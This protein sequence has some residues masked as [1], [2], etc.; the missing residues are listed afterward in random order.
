M[1]SLLKIVTWNA[2]GLLQ[3]SNELEIFLMRENIDICL[4]SETHLTRESQIK[5]RG[6]AGYHAYH[7]SDRARGGSSLFIKTNIEHSVDINIE[8]E[9]LQLCAVRV[10]NKHL[11]Y[12][13]ASIYCPPRCSLEKDD[14]FRVFN[15]LGSN[16]LIGGDLNAKHTF[17]GS[18]CTSSKGK[19]LYEVANEFGCCFH[20]TG[21]PTYWPTD[22]GKIP[23]LVDFFVTKGIY[24]KFIAVEESFDLS[25]DHSP[26]ILL[27]GEALI[28]KEGPPRLTSNRTNWE[29]FRNDC[30]TNIALNVSLKTPFELEDEVDRFVEAIQRAAWR[31]TPSRSY[32]I[33]RNEK[34]PREI[35]ELVREKRK[36]RKKWQNTRA[37]QHKTVL[38]RL[39]N[40]LRDSIREFKSNKIATYLENLS[41]ERESNYSLWKA[42]K[43]IRKPQMQAPPIRKNDR[44]WA[45]SDKEKA[46]LFALHLEETFKPFDGPSITPNSPVTTSDNFKLKKVA[47]TELRK[48]IKNLKAKKAPG[49]DL[50]TAHVVKELPNKALIKLLYLI[51]A[52]FRLLYV[53]RQWKVAEIIMVP[54]PGKPL[55]EKKSY[56]PISLLP[57]ISK[58]FEKLL[59]KRLQP[60]IDERRLIPDHQFGFRIKHSTIDQ[61]HKITDVIEKALEEKKICCGVFLDV[62]QAFDKV[63][64]EGLEHKLQ[65]LL[66]RQL[67]LILRSYLTERL[68]RVKHGN[69]YSDFK[70]IAA[71][72]P[73]GSV[74]GPLLYILYTRDIP[75]ERNCVVATFAD[76]T[77]IL[78]TGDTIESATEKLQHAINKVH[79]WTN[80]WRIVLN[81]S[82]S[83]HVNFTYKK[84]DRLPVYLN[85]A[86]IPYANE[87]KYLG[88][89]LDAKLKWKSHVKKKREEL[90]NKYRQMYWLLG[91]HS[92]LSLHNKLLIYKQVLKPVWTY[93]LQL[94]GCTKKS[95]RNIL[96]TFENKVLRTIVSAPW[97][98]R[99]EDIHRDL[100]IP[101][102]VEEI[103][104]FARK[105]KDRVHGHCNRTVIQLLDAN[106]S[107]RRL[108]RTKPFDL[109][110]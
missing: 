71:G 40:R 75:Q 65:L 27:L 87:A 94:W 11:S 13:I 77:A 28:K 44:T 35:I 17:W 47:L 68:F 7:P 54:K 6:Y 86:Q 12:N 24:E 4:I 1:D 108:Q 69:D 26:V 61:V 30:E 110:S 64:H 96:Q 21:K 10:K 42:L 60:V 58:I 72:V 76:D 18:R 74:L 48:V 52:S 81:E 50:I 37:P 93:G 56:R 51:N 2:N 59:S 9:K 46:E 83:T 82:K 99:N 36:A 22:S 39:C 92:K 103:T 14:Y 41:A 20:S 53:P 70:E 43:G 89:T 102:V 55:N 84:V 101:S 32:K 63:W 79:G 57:V 31:N 3:K 5:I 45:K 98:V 29:G 33:N 16:F 78:T 95:N 73:Q 109:A 105:H 100:G 90:E 8:L 15:A 62:S 66:P 85:S 38:N 88:M 49:Y 91:K 104:K 19:I 106:N 97:Y 80:S 34:Y 25:S 23:D 107:I 67:F